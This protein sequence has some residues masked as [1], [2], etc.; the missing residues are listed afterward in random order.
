MG[1]WGVGVGR[2]WR[3]LGQENA[4]MEVKDAIL[5]P[6]RDRPRLSRNLGVMRG[7]TLGQVESIS[8][9]NGRRC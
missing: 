6:R 2:A 7:S 9:M 4:R 8:V 3:E 5:V 1:Q